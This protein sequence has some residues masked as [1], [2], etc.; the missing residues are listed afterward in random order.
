LGKVLFSILREKVLPATEQVPYVAMLPFTTAVFSSGV[1][2]S[3]K[4]QDHTVGQSNRKAIGTSR[5]RG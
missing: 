1:P 2:A 4:A 3:R 5:S